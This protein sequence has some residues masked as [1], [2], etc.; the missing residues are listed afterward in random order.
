M[1]HIIMPGAHAFSLTPGR[2]YS[3]SRYSCGL[4]H[5]TQAVILSA[6]IFIENKGRRFECGFSS[7]FFF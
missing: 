5:L 6:L 2:L 3:S 7:L 4:A 1:L